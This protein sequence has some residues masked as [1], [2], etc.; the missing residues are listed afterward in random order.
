VSPSPHLRT[1]IDS[2]SETLCFLVFEYRTTDKDQKPRDIIIQHRQNPSESSTQTP[3]PESA[4]ELYRPNDSRLLAKL[5]P[6]FVGSLQVTACLTQRL[7]WNILTSLKANRCFGGTYRLHLQ[8]RGRS[9]V[10]NQRESRWQA[11]FFELWLSE[12]LNYQTAQDFK[13]EG[14]DNN[15][16]QS[17][18]H[19]APVSVVGHP[20]LINNWQTPTLC[21]QR[22]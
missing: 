6:T 5:V 3:W 22:C 13:A 8:V 18:P 11:Q 1:E 20:A 17:V 7:L 16:S 21:G 15:R 14:T 19:L 10:R 4:S 12:L 9:R 2:V